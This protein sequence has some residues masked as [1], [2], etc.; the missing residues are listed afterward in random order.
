MVL[1]PDLVNPAVAERRLGVQPEKTP[2]VSQRN[3]LAHHG[4]RRDSFTMGVSLVKLPCATV[5]FLH[6]VRA[7]HCK[8]QLGPSAY[9]EELL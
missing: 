9:V 4:A 1:V 3:A 8:S 7:E 2:L 6:H 5:G